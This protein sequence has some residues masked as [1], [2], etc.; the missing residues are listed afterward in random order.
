[1]CYFC[2][3]EKEGVD[4]VAACSSN[5]T[6]F[7]E[8]CSL[9]DHFDK[10]VVVQA[11]SLSKNTTIF[12]RECTTRRLCEERSICSDPDFSDC[13]YECCTGDLCNNFNFTDEVATKTLQPTVAMTTRNYQEVVEGGDEMVVTK[14]A[15]QTTVA[16]EITTHGRDHEID[17]PATTIQRLSTTS[18]SNRD[19]VK[20]N[21]VN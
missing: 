1:M 15:R 6:L 13:R 16:P 9:D 11:F 2:M 20:G 5:D 3:G 19:Q 7:I 4:N 8:E 14:N 10:C 17:D 12:K 18:S 21:I